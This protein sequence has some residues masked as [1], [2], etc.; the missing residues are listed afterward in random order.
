MK[1]AFV[2]LGKHFGGAENYLFTVIKSW[3]KDGNT[4][5]LILRN[6]SEFHMKAISE[7]KNVE[8]IPV[9]FKFKD[10]LY[11]KKRL[12]NCDLLNI[13]G[14]NSGVFIRMCFTK[15]PKVTTVHS[16]SYMDRVERKKIIRLLF[17]YLENWCL[18]DATKIICV[19][20][21]IQ[22]VLEK[23]GV[24]KNKTLVI[25]NGVKLIEYP[26]KQLRSEKKSEL[27]LCFIGRLEKVKG[28]EILLR[29]LK[30]LKN[31]NIKCDIY[32]VGTLENDLKKKACDNELS[33][34]V[35]FKGFSKEIRSVLPKYD[36]VILP[37]L[38][39]AFPLTIPEA[40]NAKTLIVC[41]N[42]GGMP[43]IIKE[44]YNGHLFQSENFNE[45]QNCL[46]E[47]YHNPNSQVPLINNAYDDFV[48]QYS[49]DIM[50]SRTLK[51]F[52]SAVKK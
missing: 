22:Q 39:E 52:K 7:L 42:V 2:D 4:A 15:I 17:V 43:W 11:V 48:N 6:N 49:E 50:I 8:I 12:L 38:F 10:F 5:I 24:D 14:I 23:R 18:K 20:E 28:C 19:S 32:G 33:N 37:S 40:M 3:M 16:N 13:N 1:C 25:H 21:A 29:A 9:E 51:I 31:Y 36:V 26:C 35:S 45:L 30:N 47:I 27:K 41:S 44:G 46:L 34:I